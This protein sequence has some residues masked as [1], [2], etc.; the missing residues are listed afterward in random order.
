MEELLA[1]KIMRSIFFTEKNC[2]SGGKNIACLLKILLIAF[3]G[4]GM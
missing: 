2:F 1:A 4:G 3:A